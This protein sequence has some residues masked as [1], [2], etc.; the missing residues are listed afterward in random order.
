MM[1]CL[2]TLAGHALVGVL[3]GAL[4]H[5][6]YS[7]KV[8][9]LKKLERGSDAC[10]LVN[11]ANLRQ[12]VLVEESL[13]RSSSRSRSFMQRVSSLPQVAAAVEHSFRNILSTL[14][15]RIFPHR[16]C[17]NHYLKT[18]GSIIMCLV[19]PLVLIAIG[20]PVVVYLEDWKLYDAI[21]WCTIT[22]TTVG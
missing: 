19:P 1:S 10:T 16:W 13:S 17:Q 15:H 11:E 6:A 5:R 2:F 14:F 20:A 18:L 9:S 12:S 3:I 8:E 22:G 7:K 21:Y 4:S